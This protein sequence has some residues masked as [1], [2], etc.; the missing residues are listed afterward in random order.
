[1]NMN[2]KVSS[3]VIARSNLGQLMEVAD[4][5]DM[6][7]TRSGKVD[8]RV[9][10]SLVMK[11]KTTAKDGTG[12]YPLQVVLQRVNDVPYSVNANDKNA[13]DICEMY[14]ELAT[15]FA[16]DFPQYVWTNETDYGTASKTDRT[17]AEEIT[18]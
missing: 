7:T 13:S 5:K 12:S 10:K 6:L 17:I 9:V 1:M 15:V 8:M 3:E 16:S 11:A 18:F 14:A 4:R 2:L